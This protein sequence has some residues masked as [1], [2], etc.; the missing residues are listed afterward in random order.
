M[1]VQ[2]PA[3]TKKIVWA[4]DAFE[5]KGGPQLRVA[6]VIRRFQ[7]KWPGVVIQPAH[8][9]SPAELN[10]S[11][12]FVGPWVGQYLPAAEQSLGRLVDELGLKDIERPEIVTQTTASTWRAADALIAYAER[13]RADMILVGTHG[14]TGVSR[15]LLGSFAE[16]LLLRSHV[17]V[18][19][20]GPHLRGDANYGELLFPTD[21]GEYAKDIFRSVLGLAKGLGSSI[22]LY[23]AIPKPIEPVYQSGV[24]LLGSPWLPVQ[25]YYNREMVHHQHHMDAWAEWANRQGVQVDTVIDT[26]TNNIAESILALARKRKPGWIAMAAHNGPI[27]SAFLGSVTRKV[28]RGAECPVWVVRLERE[29]AHRMRMRSAG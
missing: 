23:H 6:E 28:V 18:M 27:A 11:A 14:R 13:V 21:F 10:L 16:S 17:P 2:H 8:I 15:L 7:Q 25:D 24:Y 22:T 19:V 29:S 20:V 3:G 9:L 5:E 26:D 1:E 12:E 4:V